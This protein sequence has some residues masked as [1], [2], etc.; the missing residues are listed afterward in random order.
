MNDK[1]EVL[2]SF[3]ILAVAMEGLTQMYTSRLGSG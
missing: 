3:F 2:L 1:Q